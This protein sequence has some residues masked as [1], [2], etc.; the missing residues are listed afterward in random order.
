M[1][2]SPPPARV[3]YDD[4]RLRLVEQSK[5]YTLEYLAGGQAEYREVYDCKLCA[6]RALL[7]ATVQLQGH[8]HCSPAVLR[9]E[10]PDIIEQFAGGPN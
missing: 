9:I 4:T 1:D 5:L 8:C 7:L 10:D 6:I 2:Q 3:L